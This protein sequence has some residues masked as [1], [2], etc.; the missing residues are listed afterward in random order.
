[1]RQKLAELAGD[2][3]I[4]VSLVAT[5]SEVPK[6][7]QT[8]SSKVFGPVEKLTA[9]YWPGVPVVA[10][11][12]AGAS[13]GAFLIPAGI[14]T[15]GVSGIFFDADGSGAH[16]LNEHVRTA[17]VYRGRDFIYDIVKSYANPE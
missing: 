15:Y 11:M 16:G 9:K 7:P 8:L 6:S 2:P 3:D 10:V 1:M 14:P 12:A 5:P 13:D 4:K 17:S